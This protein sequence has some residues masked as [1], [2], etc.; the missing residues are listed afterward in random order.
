[1]MEPIKLSRI[2]EEKAKSLMSQAQMAQVI[3]QTYIQG[4]MD[5]QHIDG[6]YNLDTNTWTLVPFDEPEG[7]EQ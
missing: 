4:V 5:A 1:M 7:G 2:V 3:F 6:N